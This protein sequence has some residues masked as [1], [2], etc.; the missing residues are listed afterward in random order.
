LGEVDLFFSVDSMQHVELHTLIAYWLNAAASLRV[1]GHI[2]MTVATCTTAKGFSRLLDEAAWCYGGTR[3]SH[4]FYF[5]SK[6]VVH[7]CLGQLGFEV[8]RLEEGR[9]INVVARKVRPVAV[10]LQ[11]VP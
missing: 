9:D 6:E 4:Q 1:G 5:L 11:P 10:V 8:L 2:V 7:Y 3:P